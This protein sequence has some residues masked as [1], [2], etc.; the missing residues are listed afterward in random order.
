[1]KK[2][3][4]V[5]KEDNSSYDPVSAFVANRKGNS[6]MKGSSSTIKKTQV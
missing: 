1:M 6:T 4:F 3:V 5:E 2:I